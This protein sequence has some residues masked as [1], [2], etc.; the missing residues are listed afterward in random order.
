[1]RIDPG[2]FAFVPCMIFI[3]TCFPYRS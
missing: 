1:V 3:L 2:I